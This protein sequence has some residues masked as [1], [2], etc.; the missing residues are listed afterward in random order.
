[1]NSSSPEDWPR[2]NTHAYNTN[3]GYHNE[4]YNR[5][6]YDWEVS[7]IR[8]YFVPPPARV[9]VGACGTGREMYALATLGYQVAGFDPAKELVSLCQHHVP[10]SK[11]LCC[12]TADYTTFIQGLAPL[13]TH[14]P[15]AAGIVGFGSFAHIAT[16]SERTAVLKIFHQLCGSGPLLISWVAR[17]PSR[18]QLQVRN[19]LKRLGVNTAPESDYYTTHEGF[20]HCFTPSEFE[21][22]VAQAGYEIAYCQQEPPYPHAVLVPR[23]TER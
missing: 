7:C 9:L 1:M 14:A 11:L 20:V 10:H 21:G 12:L 17:G 4:A 22:I 8:N 2:L 23:S 18:G 3:T 15:F 16:P 19:I 13:Q 5:S 6:L